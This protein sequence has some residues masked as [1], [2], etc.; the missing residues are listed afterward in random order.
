MLGG[1]FNKVLMTIWPEEER[2]DNFFRF[3]LISRWDPFSNAYFAI[4]RRREWQ[5]FS[6]TSP[7]HR[8]LAVQIAA[9]FKTFVEINYLKD[10]LLISYDFLFRSFPPT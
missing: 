2:L 9:N 5:R 10:F 8:A 4:Q 3:D 1:V 7:R 6:K